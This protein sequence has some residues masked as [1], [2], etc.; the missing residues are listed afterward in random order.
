MRRLGYN[1]EEW[2]V[3]EG[4]AREDLCA[5]TV[6]EGELLREE[7]R[8]GGREGSLWQR[9]APGDVASVRTLRGVSDEAPDEG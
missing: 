7:R 8:V 6:E 9:P 5:G 1:G 4:Y 2:E 3:G